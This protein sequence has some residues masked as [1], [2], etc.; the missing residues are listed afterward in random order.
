MQGA[1]DRPS[2]AP[3]RAGDERRLAG[4]I[5]HGFGSSDFSCALPRRR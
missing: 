5:E 4:Q 3:G 1:R 2:E